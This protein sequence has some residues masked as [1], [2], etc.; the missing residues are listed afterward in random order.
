MTSQTTFSEHLE[1]RKGEWVYMEKVVLVQ[2]EIDKLNIRIDADGWGQRGGSAWFDD[3]KIEQLDNSQNEIVSETNYYPFGLAH[4]GYNEQT[5]SSNLGEHWKFNGKELNDEFDLGWYDFGARFYDPEINR[6]PTID[7]LA[8]DPTQI[9]K[10]PY[11]MFWN[12]PTKYIDPTGMISETVK[13]EDEKALEAIKNTLSEKDRSAVVIDADGNIDRDIINN[14]SSE[15]G[16]FNA[17]KEL[18]NSDVVVEVSVSDSY[19]IKDKN[20][21]VKTEEIRPVEIYNDMEPSPMSVQ[22]GEFGLY[23]ITQT[24]EGNSPDENVHVTLNSSLSKE[25]QAQIYSHEA[26]GHALLYIRG[27]DHK[28]RVRNDNGVFRETNTV[29]KNNIVRSIQET[30][31]NMKKN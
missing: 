29:L 1:Y 5:S 26:N 20:G 22:T 24:P 17:L 30:I 21:E 6:T 16:N 28:H 25:G 4:K 11:A 8:D 14:H 10:S 23:G 31:K 9:D 13:P 27:N 3:L 18:V 19:E 2:P 15:S 7:P 12:N